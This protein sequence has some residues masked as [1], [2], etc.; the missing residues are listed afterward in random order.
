M[1]QERDKFLLKRL[2]KFSSNTIRKN[3]GKISL[4]RSSLTRQKSLKN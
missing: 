3:S 2:K 1:A 4:I